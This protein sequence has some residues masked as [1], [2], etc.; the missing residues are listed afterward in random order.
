MKKSI[1]PV[2]ILVLAAQTVLAQYQDDGQK[3]KFKRENIFIGSSLNLGVSSGIFQIGA[4]PEIGYSI[5]KW[6]DAGISTNINYTSFRYTNGISD[7]Y[8]VYGGGAFARIWPV[9]FLFL[10]SQNEYNRINITR[11]YTSG[12]PSEKQH[13]NANS[14]LLGA[15]YGNRIVGQTY[16]YLAIMFDASHDINSPYRDEYGRA[17]PI[18]RAGFAVYLRPKRER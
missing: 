16:S 7:R 13:F 11:K 15:G 8:F 6:L 3:G 17:I 2:L 9:R 12:L 4:N 18:F 5:T 14:V 10:T 1:V